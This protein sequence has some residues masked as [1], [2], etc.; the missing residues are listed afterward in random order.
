MKTNV[1]TGCQATAIV[2]YAARSL[3][4]KVVIRVRVVGEHQVW[5]HAGNV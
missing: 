2:G 3:K 4:V 5:C 1:G